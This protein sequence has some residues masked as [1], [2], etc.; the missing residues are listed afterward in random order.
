MPVTVRRVDY[1]YAS[2]EDV[3]GAAYKMLARLAGEGVSLVAF[4]AVPMG[5]EHTQLQL[6]AD[7]PDR[8]AEAASDADIC[9]VGPQR[10][11]LIQGDDH[12]GALADLH[13]TLADQG[14]NVY[15]SSGVTDGRG[16]YGYL[17]Y[18][19]AE[20]YDRAAGVLGV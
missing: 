4:S 12:L 11:F 5:P 6:F 2:V 14:V 1:Y 16:G 10:A 8:L 19:R 15:A 18:V 13:R 20:Q 17:L 9:L 3:P 7:D